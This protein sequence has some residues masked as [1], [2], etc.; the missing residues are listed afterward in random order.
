MNQLLHR[1][2]GLVLASAAIFVSVAVASERADSL[3]EALKEADRVEVEVVDHERRPDAKPAFKFAGAEKIATLVKDFDFNDAK[4]GFHCMCDGDYLVTFYKG[5]K[6]LATISYHHAQSLRWNGG[7]WKQDSLFT[8]DSAKAWRKWFDDIG[9]PRFENQYKEFVAEANRRRAIHEKFMAAFPKGAAEIFAEQNRGVVTASPANDSRREEELSPA[10]TKLIA[11][12]PDRKG[13]GLAAAKSLGGLCLLSGG[14]GWWTMSTAREQLVLE[15][16][17]T[18]KGDEFLEV[19]QSKDDEVLL[20][21]ARLFFFERLSERLP[22]DQRGPVAA[23]LSEVVFRLDQRQNADSAVRM[24]ASFP[25]AET[26]ALLERLAAGE[27]TVKPEPTKYKPEPIPAAAACVVLARAKSD[28]VGELA[29]K[30]EAAGGLDEMDRAALKVARSLG[31]ERGVLDKS[32]F[33]VKSGTVGFYAL[34]ALEHEG[35]KAA[36]DAVIMGG[37][38]HMWAAVRQEAVLATERMTGKKWCKGDENERPDWY[39]DEVQAWWQENRETYE[40][41]KTK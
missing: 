2:L 16:A 15:C 27:I 7:E 32:I 9:E 37:T 25:C 23:R 6:K 12:F 39:C 14:E 24:L 18:L 10:A 11:L 17:R 22:K 26:M 13:L 5:E 21:A 1:C 33:E 40:Q 4:S 41:P 30:I 8:A 34:E 35:G 20:G 36:L 19:L 3:R 38:N 29:K 31:G 28:K